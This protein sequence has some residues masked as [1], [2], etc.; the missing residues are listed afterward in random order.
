PL[1]TENL[2]HSRRSELA[3]RTFSS[4]GRTTCVGSALMRALPDAAGQDPLG[5]PRA[6]SVSRRRYASKD[7]LGGS[8][9]FWPWLPQLFGCTPW[10]STPAP[11]DPSNVLRG[12]LA[13]RGPEHRKREFRRPRTCRRGSLASSPLP[14]VAC[15]T[16]T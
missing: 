6:T 5:E 4:A 2:L 10:C 14:H 13:L 8:R 7:S 1:A 9:L 16:A 11:S 15:N 12:L 3:E